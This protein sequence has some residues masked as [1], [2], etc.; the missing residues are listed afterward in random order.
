MVRPS[1]DLSR[2]TVALL[3]A[4]AVVGLAHHTDHVL[5]VDHSGWPFTPTVTPFTYSLLAYPVVLF[6]LFG[7]PRLIWLRWAA[8][9]VGALMT[10]AA[11]TLIETPA[12]QYGSWATGYSID[13]ETAGVQNLLCIQSPAMGVVAVAV[14]MA[15]NLI[16]LAATV[17]LAWDAARRR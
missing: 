16:V 13:P 4:L 9:L 15:L 2:R 14:S 5:R 1:S 3:T 7:P 17:S 12:M 6:A 8:V 10:I 11:H